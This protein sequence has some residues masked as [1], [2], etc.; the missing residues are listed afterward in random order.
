MKNS[1]E[2]VCEAA[3]GLADYPWTPEETIALGNAGLRESADHIAFAIVT[4]DAVHRG[5]HP[6]V[7]RALRGAGFQLIAHRSLKL[8]DDQIEELYKYGVRKKIVDHRRT[9]WFLTRKGL[10]FGVS[11]G[12]LLHHPQPGA[13]QRLLV[14]K[15]DSDPGR[16]TATSVRGAV[17]SYSKILAVMHSSDD[18]AAVMRESLL[19]FTR[20]E[21]EDAIGTKARDSPNDDI[22]EAVTETLSTTDVSADPM[23]IFWAVKLRVAH[24]LLTHPLAPEGLTSLSREHLGLLRDGRRSARR[25]R[26]DW[27][28]ALSDAEGLLARERELLDGSAFADECGRAMSEGRDRGDLALLSWCSLVLAAR[29]LADTSGFRELQTGR[30]LGS[31]HEAGVHVTPWE[32]LVLENLLHFWEA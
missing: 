9:H 12:M 2:A 19:Y 30:L 27:L 1:F 15:G 20:Q 3:H 31:L 5:Q 7:L 21:V 6:A 24:V 11:V 22:W 10:G 25:G 13:C 18:P 29:R 17:R 16:A 23:E 4:P 28:A 26:G 8:R 32:S 14:L